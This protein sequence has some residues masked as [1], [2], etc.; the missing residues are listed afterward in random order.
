MPPPS[1]APCPY[2]FPSGRAV[3]PPRRRPLRGRAR[4]DAMAPTPQMLAN[5]LAP[6][7]PLAP[8][9][10]PAEPPV[11]LVDEA[12]AEMAQ[13]F[14][15][16]EGVNGSKSAQAEPPSSV[17]PYASPYPPPA[18]FPPD[19][20][21]SARARTLCAGPGRGARRACGARGD[22]R[23]PPAVEIPKIVSMEMFQ[24]DFH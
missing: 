6:L 11:A 15:L 12:L 23:G 13:A 1:P 24:V 17:S 18:A 16:L 9:A 7:E 14:E 8:A 19:S 20:R 3:Q 10:A 2:A 4:V 5:G 21:L 22:R